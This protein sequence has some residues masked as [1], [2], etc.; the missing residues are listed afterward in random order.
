M[1]NDEDYFI[2]KIYF[3]PNGFGFVNH[4]REEKNYFVKKEN[5]GRSFHEDIVLAKKFMINQNQRLKSLWLS[6]EQYQKL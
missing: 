5:S 2:G 1:N 6:G 4:F 3:S